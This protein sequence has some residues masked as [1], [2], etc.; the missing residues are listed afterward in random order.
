MSSR[1]QR[2]KMTHVLV[3][4]SSDIPAALI[5]N[6]TL[7]VPSDYEDSD[8]GKKSAEFV[9]SEK[10]STTNAAT[11]TTAAPREFMTGVFQSISLFAEDFGGLTPEEQ[12]VDPLLRTINGPSRSLRGRADDGMPRFAHSG[13]PE[14]R[15]KERW[16]ARFNELCSFRARYGHCKVPRWYENKALANWV[17]RCRQEYRMAEEEMGSSMTPERFAMLNSINFEW[18]STP[19]KLPRKVSKDQG[20]WNER[21]MEMFHFKSRY[22]HCSVPEGWKDNPRLAQWVIDQRQ[23]YQKYLAKQRSTMTQERYQRLAALGF[24]WHSSANAGE[25]YPTPS[26]IPKHRLLTPSPSSAGSANGLASRQSDIDQS[27]FRKEADDATE[28]LSFDDG[29]N[30][31]VAYEENHGTF[32]VPV[33]AG[34]LY[35]WVQRQIIPYIQRDMG[36]PSSMKD[37]SFL[38]LKE[39]GAFRNLTATER[40]WHLMYEELRKYIAD[41]GHMDG[42][43]AINDSLSTWCYT[44]RC[45][46]K[47][48]LSNDS[49][50]SEER[51][52]KVKARCAKLN[53]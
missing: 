15:L 42:I 33:D 1:K 47:Q 49:N 17:R 37:S 32:D 38:K 19:E 29:F 22:G 8:D 52:A 27:T 48:I 50:C 44:Q 30:E 12:G 11:V 7:P 26:P 20:Q 31:L 21:C 2:R 16:H 34:K 23:E 35:S 43:G 5:C 4:V 24:L 13:R 10:N 9:E 41:H 6:E 39:I 3:A 45:V 14:S 51:R 40:R 46:L 25:L 36:E 18:P 53:A 28:L